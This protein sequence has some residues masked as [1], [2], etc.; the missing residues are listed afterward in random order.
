M[1]INANVFLKPRKHMGMMLYL[2]VPNLTLLVAALLLANDDRIN[3]TKTVQ[4]GLK[5][6]LPLY[7]GNDR[8]FHETEQGMLLATETV[9][10]FPSD[11]ARPPLHPSISSSPF[12]LIP[13]VTGE[14][15][16]RDPK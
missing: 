15:V 10:H 4:L 5:F 3:V 9:A 2:T 7:P 14:E 11:C 12:F 16:R 1:E 6:T 13:G 8:P